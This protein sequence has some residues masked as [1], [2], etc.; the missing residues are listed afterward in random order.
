[1]TRNNLREHLT[2]LLASVPSNPAPLRPPGDN[3]LHLQNPS[4]HNSIEPLLETDSVRSVQ[5]FD[6]EAHGGGEE[7]S[8]LEIPRPSASQVPVF[9]ADETMVRLQSGPRSSKKSHLLSQTDFEPLQTPKAPRSLDFIKSGTST[10]ILA[11]SKL[12]LISF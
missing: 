10:L 3:S 2:W 5:C 1:M 8:N 6:N 11:I 4:S 9:Q 7:E 12:S